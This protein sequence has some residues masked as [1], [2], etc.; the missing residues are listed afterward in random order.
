MKN[1]KTL[2]AEKVLTKLAEIWA[3]QYG[4]KITDIKVTRR[5]SNEKIFNS[6][7]DSASDC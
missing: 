4:Q 5:G 2:D 7:N 1:C 6:V 3:D